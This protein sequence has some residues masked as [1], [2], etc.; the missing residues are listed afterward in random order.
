MV[1][2]GWKIRNDSSG[3]IY[4]PG[5]SF[6]FDSSFA[7]SLSELDD[8][9]QLVTKRTI[10]LD[11]VYRELENATIVYDANGGTI[12]SRALT[13]GGGQDNS[14][15]PVVHTEGTDHPLTTKYA[16]SGDQLIVSDL[17]NNS[18]VRLAD[19]V[20]F[21]N[22]GYTFVGWSTTP[23]G[24]DGKF[25]RADSINCYVDI[26]EP[27]VLYAQ[28]EVRVYFDKNNINA[29]DNTIGWGGNWT[30][31][32]YYWSES[33]QKYYIT[34][35]LGETLEQPSYIPKSNNE[36]E[37]FKYWSLRKQ[38]TSGV[39]EAPFDFGTPITQALVDQ[40][41]TIYTDSSGAAK[42]MAWIQLFR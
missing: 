26:E 40:Y 35:F 10:I 41:A 37:M 39:M 9:G 2:I 3:I 28:W 18:A 5:Q 7:T 38:N 36:E 15:P 29:P 19:G 24:E 14:R 30:D 42:Y 21:S 8:N 23:S 34:I 22:A 25:F 32:G 31:S 6:Q 16:I 12:D 17:M 13:H 4:Y 20:G 27:L 33:Q 1:F 11:A